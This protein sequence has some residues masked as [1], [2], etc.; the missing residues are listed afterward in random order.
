M[1]GR[2]PFPSGKLQLF[3][4]PHTRSCCRCPIYRFAC[5]AGTLTR[6]DKSDTLKRTVDQGLAAARRESGR[7]PTTNGP[8]PA[9]TGKVVVLAFL[10]GGV[11]GGKTN[12]NFVAG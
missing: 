4:A 1:P 7:R 2:R 11:E 3:S 10:T 12:T 8:A 5:V 6:T 9:A